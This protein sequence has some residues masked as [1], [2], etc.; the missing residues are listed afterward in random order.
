MAEFDPY[1]AAATHLGARA[2]ENPALCAA[3]VKLFESI[4][5]HGTASNFESLADAIEASGKAVEELANTSAQHAKIATNKKQE[6]EDT[7]A[8]ER[9]KNDLDAEKSTAPNDKKRKEAV[10]KRKRLAE[11]WALE[12]QQYV[13]KRLKQD[14]QLKAV[15]MNLVNKAQLREFLLLT[16]DK[17]VAKWNGMSGDEQKPYLVGGGGEWG[18]GAVSDVHFP[19]PEGMV[20]LA[21]AIDCGDNTAFAVCETVQKPTLRVL[22]SRHA[23]V[24]HLI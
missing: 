12:L 9:A 6:A 23:S 18:K 10:A 13:S 8:A 3:D 1:G 16:P 5:G 11:E 17:A 20:S 22:G 19:V 7:L 24:G 21:G 15:F 14:L 4:N 2:K